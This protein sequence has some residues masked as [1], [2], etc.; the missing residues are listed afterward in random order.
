MVAKTASQISPLREIEMKTRKVKTAKITEK[1]IMLEVSTRLSYAGWRVLRVPP[2]IYSSKGWC[3]VITVKKGTVL[4]LEFKSEKGKQSP[5]QKN[6]Q[7]LI[8]DAGG[9]YVLVRSWSDM[10]NVI[11]GKS[12][13][14]LPMLD[15]ENENHLTK[16]GSYYFL[17]ENG[18]LLEIGETPKQAKFNLMKRR[19]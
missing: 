16:K 4:F 5:D 19:G 7:Q 13:Y 6:F 2:S 10:E 18:K 9:N 8:E 15:L 3:D 12:D 1:S 11:K 17:G 14:K